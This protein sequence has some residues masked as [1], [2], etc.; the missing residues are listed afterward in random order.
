MF[1]IILVEISF[2]IKVGE[3]S[4]EAYENIVFIYTIYIYA[5]KKKYALNYSYR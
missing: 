3:T 1:D 4:K 2:I 5:C